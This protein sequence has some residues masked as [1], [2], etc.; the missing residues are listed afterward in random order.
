MNRNSLARQRF[1]L[2]AIKEWVATGPNANWVRLRASKLAEGVDVQLGEEQYRP[3]IEAFPQSMPETLL[4]ISWFYV[5]TYILH[6]FAPTW[7]G[8]H[9]ARSGS[10]EVWADIREIPL[11]RACCCIARRR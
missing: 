1:V 4:V 9:R 11:H 7:L 3:L 8:L 5:R 2:Q 6:R 10:D